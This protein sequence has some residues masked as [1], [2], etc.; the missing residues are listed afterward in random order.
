MD[1]SNPSS[2]VGQCQ[3]TFVIVI[4]ADPHVRGSDERT[5]LEAESKAEAVV[6]KGPKL[7]TNRPYAHDVISVGRPHLEVKRRLF[8][9][10]YCAPRVQICASRLFRHRFSS[11]MA[12]G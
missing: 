10:Q 6:S 1:F 9:G 7:V 2:L 3:F 5:E 4:I 8:I 11:K 12:A